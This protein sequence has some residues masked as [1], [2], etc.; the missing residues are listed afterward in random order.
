MFL[1]KRFPNI[2]HFIWNNLD[3]LMMRKTDT[4]MSTLPNF[5]LFKESLNRAMSFLD[6]S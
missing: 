3:P 4:A 5:D 6:N 1:V 2:R